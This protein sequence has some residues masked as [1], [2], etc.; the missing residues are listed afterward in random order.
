MDFSALVIVAMLE[1]FG[2]LNFGEG[3]N[4]ATHTKT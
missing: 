4:V 2:I 3:I 1:A